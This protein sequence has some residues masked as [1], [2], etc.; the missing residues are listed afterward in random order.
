LTTQFAKGKEGALKF[1]RAEGK[2]LRASEQLDLAAE[3]IVVDGLNNCVKRALINALTTGQSSSQTPASR[4]PALSDDDIRPLQ[5]ALTELGYS[6]GTADGRIGPKTRAAIKAFQLSEQLKTDGLASAELLARVEA[7]LAS[8]PAPSANPQPS[9]P[10]SGP[11]LKIG[12]IGPTGEPKIRFRDATV[13]QANVKLDTVFRKAEILNL[14]TRAAEQRTDIAL[15]ADINEFTQVALKGWTPGP[16]SDR[17]SGRQRQRRQSRTIDLFAV[18][19][20]SHRR[21]LGEWPARHRVSP[22]RRPRGASKA[23]SI[24]N[25]TTSPS[26]P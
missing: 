26:D 13:K 22:A 24:L 9:T 18:P 5:T 7:R 25:S 12:Q 4:S 11:Q 16:E 10:T 19:G 14:D 2:A 21:L 8:P 6:S 1:R 23:R 20:R 3:K 15:T 17:R